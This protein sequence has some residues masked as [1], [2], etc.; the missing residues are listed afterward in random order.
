[1]FVNTK[2]RGRSLSEVRV[3]RK[4]LDDEEDSKTKGIQ[5]LVV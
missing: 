4:L 3:T 5:Q 1:M 2:G